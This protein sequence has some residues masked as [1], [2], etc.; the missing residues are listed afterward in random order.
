M[1]LIFAASHSHRF[2]LE[3]KLNTLPAS[4]SIRI[5]GNAG[6]RI[7]REWQSQYSTNVIDLLTGAYFR[8]YTIDCS[9]IYSSYLS[10]D[11]DFGLSH[12]FF[13]AMA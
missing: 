6:D 10:N 8:Q 11:S 5:S 13:V 12:L 7:L 2:L 1:C 9:F 3:S 4:L